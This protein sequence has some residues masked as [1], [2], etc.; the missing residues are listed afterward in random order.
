MEFDIFENEIIENYTLDGIYE[1]IEK[2]TEMTSDLV[3][4]MRTTNMLNTANH[5]LTSINN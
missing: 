1:E 5:Y 3:Q 2:F 4:K